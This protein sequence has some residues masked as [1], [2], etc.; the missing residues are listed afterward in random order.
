MWPNQQPTFSKSF[1][2]VAADP[3][4][5]LMHSLSVAESV[6]TSHSPVWLPVNLFFIHPSVVTTLPQCVFSLSHSR[7]FACN[8]PATRLHPYNL[9]C[10]AACHFQQ[11][12]IDSLALCGE[13]VHTPLFWMTGWHIS[14]GFSVWYF[15]RSAL[16][17]QC[18]PFFTAPRWLQPSVISIHW[19]FIIL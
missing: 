17:L 12:V 13:G 11:K 4:S 6:F 18:D 15:Y 8:P 1:P 7:V 5:H 14:I 2:D 19:V 10:L 16:I 3:C 9:F